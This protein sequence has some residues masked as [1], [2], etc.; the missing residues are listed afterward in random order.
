LN[1]VQIEKLLELAQVK[2]TADHYN[3]LFHNCNHFSDAFCVLL[4]CGNL[5]VWIFGV[6]QHTQSV[7]KP[8]ERRQLAAF[9]DPKRSERPE[10]DRGGI[11]ETCKAEPSSPPVKRSVRLG[12]ENLQLS[13]VLA[14]PSMPVSPDCSGNMESTLPRAAPASIRSNL[15]ATPPNPKI[16]PLTAS[17]SLPSSP[18]T[19]LQEKT[20]QRSSD[21]HREA[22]EAAAAGT[23]LKLDFGDARLNKN[24]DVQLL[25]SEMD[26][27]GGH[28]TA[29]G[30]GSSDTHLLQAPRQ[31][32]ISGSSSIWKEV[33]LNSDEDAEGDVVGDGA[34][35][36]SRGV[37]T[38]TRPA[39]I[40]QEPTEDNA[41]HEA[42]AADLHIGANPPGGLPPAWHFGPKAT[43]EGARPR[44]GADA[45]LDAKEDLLG[46]AMEE[47]WLSFDSIEEACEGQQHP[48]KD[49]RCHQH[50]QLGRQPKL[51][52]PQDCEMNEKLIREL[53]SQAGDCVLLRWDSFAAEA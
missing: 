28:W 39:G 22:P 51:P 15:K 30:L 44:R 11:F 38:H 50:G 36:S 53:R 21:V 4:G 2:W 6:L 37:D 1:V 25:S 19:N 27:D 13:P 17:P 47:R 23:R 32:S 31:T 46:L 18:E 48:C 45:I 40:Y 33:T 26:L 12:K 29:A 8:P 35:N 49:Y 5:P 9:Q 52:H 3:M 43:Q 41:W 42:I 20:L 16:V 10:R 34:S 14:S 7:P 24:K